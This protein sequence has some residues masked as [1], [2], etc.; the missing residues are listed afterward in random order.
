MT[1]AVT[2]APVL[3]LNGV[4]HKTVPGTTR[5]CD[6]AY[7]YAHTGITA[8]RR[9]DGDPGRPTGSGLSSS[10][11]MRG[12]TALPIWERATIFVL[13]QRYVVGKVC[14]RD[15][16]DGRRAECSYPVLVG[17]T[18]LRLRSAST[19]GDGPVTA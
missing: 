8:A 18:Q 7:V 10:L 9:N 13:G 12:G 3:D 15:N 4:M 11:L 17:V 16:S 14:S 5:R 6:A 1:W 19:V 2:A